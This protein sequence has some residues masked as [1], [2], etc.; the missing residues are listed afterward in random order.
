MKKNYKQQKS[1]HKFQIKNQNKFKNNRKCKINSWV[2]SKDS[3]KW[4]KRVIVKVII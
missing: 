2:E 3:K 1:R 4:N